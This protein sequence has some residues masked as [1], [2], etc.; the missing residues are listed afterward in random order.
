MSFVKQFLEMAKLLELSH[1]DNTF[2]LRLWSQ[3]SKLLVLSKSGYVS[4]IPKKHIKYASSEPYLQSVIPDN[5]DCVFILFYFSMFYF[6][7]SEF[8]L[9]STLYPLCPQIQIDTNNCRKP[10]FS[11]I[12]FAILGY[13]TSWITINK[14]Q[15]CLWFN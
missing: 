14:I 2:P 7:F 10:T 15:Y 1:W 11:N 6:S 5:W 3:T 13:I 4:P 8:T 12:L 9:I